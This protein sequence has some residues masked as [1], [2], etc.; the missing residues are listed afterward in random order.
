MSL[1]VI[2]VGGG[3]HAH[4]VIDVLRL[5]G[6]EIL[7]VCDPALTGPGSAV[8][9]V[10]V[11]GDDEAIFAR[12][13]DSVLL[14]NAVGSTRTTASRAEVFQRF[15]ARGYRFVT[16]K[17]PSAL[18]AD[19]VA[20]GEGV[21]VMAGAVVQPGVALGDNVLVNTGASVD[22]DCRIEA[23]VHIAPGAVLSGGVALEEGVHVG[24]GAVIVQSLRVGRGS[25]V[26]AGAVVTADVPD[27]ATVRPPQASVASA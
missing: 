4:V 3:G 5:A 26:A 7:G 19:S 10:P 22:H 18:I 15:R 1:P 25:L 23:H 8:C 20:L 6:Q 17:H 21:Q 2:L 9:G 13:S 27:A 12:S 14:A 11:I 16:A 24:T